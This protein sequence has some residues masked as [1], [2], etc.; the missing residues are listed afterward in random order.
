MGSA[1]RTGYEQAWARL[2]VAHHINLLKLREVYVAHVHFFLY[3]HL[4]GQPMLVRADNVQHL[5]SIGRV[6]YLPLASAIWPTVVAMGT[7]HAPTISAGLCSD[8]GIV[9]TV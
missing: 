1:Q 2:C 9:A 8:F 5:S 4:Q 6:V 7:P 3:L